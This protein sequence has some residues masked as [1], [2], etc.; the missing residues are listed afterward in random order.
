MRPTALLSLTAFAGLAVAA[1]DTPRPVPAPARTATLPAASGSTPPVPSAPLV[2]IEGPLGIAA[3]PIDTLVTLGGWLADHPGDVVQDSVPIGAVDGYV[4]RIAVGTVEI[5]GRKVARSAVFNLPTPPAGEALPDTAG[6]AGRECHLRAIWLV[7]TELDPARAS[8]FADSLGLILDGG[9][10]PGRPGLAMSGVGTG[11]WGEQRTWTGPG[12]TVVRGVLPAEPASQ[13]EGRTIPKRVGRVIVAAFAPHS[14]LDAGRWKD[15]LADEDDEGAGERAV[16][17][18]LADSAV[19]WAGVPAFTAALRPALAY[20]RA[21]PDSARTSAVDSALV[22]SAAVVHALGNS[23]LA[24]PRRAAALVAM[25]LVLHHSARALD[26]DSTSAGAR[27]RRALEPSGAPYEFEHL[28]DGYF[29]TRAWLWEAYH[30]D[31]LG[32]AGHVALLSLLRS[33]WATRPGCAGT[34]GETG[35]VVDHGEAALARGDTDPLIHYYVGLGYHEDVSLA[36]GG[37]YDDYV[38]PKEYVPRAPASRVKAIAHLRAALGGLTD[39]RM[40][41]HAW[42]MAV[43]MMLGH[44]GQTRYFCVND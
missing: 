12:T 24:P 9:L 15:E 32:R 5:G 13:D 43:L 38:D 21:N 37:M 22:R 18:A 39:R 25:D 20:I 35:G 29:Y 44:A 40:R 41:R 11:Q 42:R 17:L 26:D 23:S 30:Q 8:R 14:G 34:P 2:P 6:L 7:A 28:G 10:G 33:D 16:E 3:G 1:C 4:C 19:G 31:S 36:R 27:L